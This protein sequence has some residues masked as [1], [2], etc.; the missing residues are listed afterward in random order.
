MGWLA[1]AVVVLAIIYFMIVSLGFRYLVISMLILAAIGIYSIIVNANKE[2]EAQHQQQ[3]EARR[4]LVGQHAEGERSATTAIRAD[5]LS[6]SNVSVVR[7]L[8]APLKHEAWWRWRLKGIIANNSKMALGSISFVVT[9]KDCPS[10][11]QCKIIGQKT[12]AT[13]NDNYVLVSPG[14]VRLFQTNEMQFK[15]MFPSGNSRWEYKITE[16]RATRPATNP[17]EDLVPPSQRQQN[18]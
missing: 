3:A 14:Q 9:V 2:S 15:N 13:R 16:I 8:Q 1:G 12:A 17:F 6:L 4:V 10:N 5:E 18:H 11:Q 7:F